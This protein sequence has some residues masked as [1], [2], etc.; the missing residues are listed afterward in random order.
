M[1]PYRSIMDFDWTSP[2]SST[3]TPTGTLNLGSI[4]QQRQ[5][6]S[7][8]LTSFR[9][10]CSTSRVKHDD[11]GVKYSANYIPIPLSNNGPI[12]MPSGGIKYTIVI[13]MNATYAPF[14]RVTPKKTPL[15]MPLEAL[16]MPVSTWFYDFYTG[17][18]VY[19]TY[20]PIPELATVPFPGE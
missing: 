13:M 2:S 20:A 16:F 14:I 7:N 5:T 18:G 17:A 6:F 4:T 15:G 3:L 8:Y 9:A 12:D 11:G 10:Q 1:G 19:G